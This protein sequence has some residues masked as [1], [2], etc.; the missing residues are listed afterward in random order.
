MSRRYIIHAIRVFETRVADAIMR[1]QNASGCTQFRADRGATARSRDKRGK[2]SERAQVMPASHRQ[3]RMS[4]QVYTCQEHPIWSRT[5]WGQRAA[6]AKLRAGGA[7][8][9]RARESAPTRQAED[10]RSIMRSAIRSRYSTGVASSTL[11]RGA[12]FRSQP[13]QGASRYSRRAP[14]ESSSSRQRSSKRAYALVS[15][16]T[17]RHQSSAELSRWMTAAHP[18][19]AP[20]A[21]PSK[22]RC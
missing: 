10:Q 21:R 20:S 13:G 16:T 22:R 3:A 5:S 17:K 11:G 12:R 18:Q 2:R 19:S 1:R 7:V 15:D 9:D 8:V 6:P 14:V 4:D